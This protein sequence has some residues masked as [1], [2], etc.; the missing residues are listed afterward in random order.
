MTLAVRPFLSRTSSTPE[1]AGVLASAILSAALSAGFSAGLS[2]GLC[3]WYLTILRSILIVIQYFPGSLDPTPSVAPV[4]PFANRIKQVRRAVQLAVVLDLF[5]AARLDDRAVIERE[6][7][8]RVLQIL[9]LHQ[10][11]LECVG[12]EAESRAALEPLLVR[13]QIN[14]LE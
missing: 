11:T 1:E 7:V 10:H 8:D 13:V 2:S 4:I 12:V 5:I 14:V 9:L 3:T 6:L